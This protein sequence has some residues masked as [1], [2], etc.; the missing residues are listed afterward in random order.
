MNAIDLGS[1]DLFHFPMRVTLDGPVDL[2]LELATANST[3][4][5]NRFIEDV[6]AALESR[7]CSCSTLHVPFTYYP[8]HKQTASNSNHH[9]SF[10]P[11]DF[12]CASRSKTQEDVLHHQHGRS[13][14]TPSQEVP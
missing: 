10:P 7:P 11:V 9:L 8:L 6:L 13:V 3:E 1:P 2:V 12:I 5:Y 14:D 4:Q